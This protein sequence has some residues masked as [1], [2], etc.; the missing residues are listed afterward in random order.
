[1]LAEMLTSAGLTCWIDREGID[2]ATSWSREIVQAIDQC[3]AFVVLL[4]PSSNESHNVAK[5]VSL[6]AEQRKKI[7]PLDLEPVTLSED[8][9]YHL[10]GIQRAPMTNIDAI[11]R[12]LGKLGLEATGTPLA[13]KIVRETDDRKSLMILPFEDL[14]PTGDNGW[15]ADGIASELI[16]AL[17]NVKALRVADPQATKEFKAYRGQIAI[18]AKEMSI[19]YFVQ[20]DIRKFGD[21]IK[22]TCRLLD[23]ESGDFLWQESLKGTMND[24]FEIQEEVAKRVTDGLNII[25]TSEE[26]KKLTERGTENADAYELFLKGQEYFARQTKEGLQ[27][28]AQLY[29]D[30]IVLDPGYALAYAGKATALANLYRSYEREPKLLEQGLDLI[31]E[32]QRLKPDLWNANSPLSAI[33]MLQGKLEEAERAAQDYVRTAPQDS[34]SHFALG[35]LYSHVGGD[36]KAIVPF[37]EAVKLKPE[38]LAAIMNLVI[39]CSGAKEDGKRKEWA[40]AAIPKFEKH[41]KLFPDD[42]SCQVQHAMLLQFADR[43][44]DAKVAARKLS[45]LKDGRSLYNIACLHCLLKDPAS[46]LATFRQAIDAGFRDIRLLNGF[47]NSEDEGVGMLRGKTEWEEVKRMVEKLSEA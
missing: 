11:I 12:A 31:H 3:K 17:S 25:L 36:A 16:T 40:R 23:I 4:S 13:P 34:G 38:N 9:R 37:E 1:M 21:N 30:A 5:E 33:L 45:N 24:V 32:A 43:D 14:S 7:L 18:Y 44:E 6:A 22:I 19:Q 28:S 35:F 42:E 20:G 29:A 8:L 47:L 2:L 10:A 39:V 27:L 26:K 15:F 41:L 46:G